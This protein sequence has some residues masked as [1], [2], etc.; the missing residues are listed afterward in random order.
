MMDKTKGEYI[1]GKMSKNGDTSNGEKLF[2]YDSYGQIR[3]LAESDWFVISDIFISQ[4]R[5]GKFTLMAVDQVIV[6]G[7]FTN[8]NKIFNTNLKTTF[9]CSSDKLPVYTG[10]IE[11]ESIC[12]VRGW[13]T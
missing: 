6:E 3:E 9:S 1:I 2:L 8:Q 13:I 12:I 4:E 11:G 7:F 5:D 10:A